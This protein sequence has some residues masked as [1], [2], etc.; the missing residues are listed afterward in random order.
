MNT[1]TNNIRV[2]ICGRIRIRIF[3][4]R[5]IFEYYSNTELFAHLWQCYGMIH[6][7]NYHLCSSCRGDFI[8]WDLIVLCT[9]FVNQYRLI[10][11]DQKR[12][13]DG[14]KHCS[15][16]LLWILITFITSH[17]WCMQW[18]KFGK[19]GQLFLQMQPFLLNGIWS[20]LQLWI[21]SCIP[22]CGKASKNRPQSLFS[23][24]L[25]EIS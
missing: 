24:V 8:H 7:W 6:L 19:S 25:Q 22:I 21:V 20:N 16:A 9:L 5:I 18:S 14:S 12:L 17:F 3:F 15:L 13:C 11:S 1:N 4:I 10:M 2:S 23:F